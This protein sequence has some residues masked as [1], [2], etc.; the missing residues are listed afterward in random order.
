MN[1]RLPAWLR[2]R[3]L[4]AALLFLVTLLVYLPAIFWGTFHYDD[5]HSLVENPG[6]RSLANIPRFFVEPQLWSA[7]PG[8]LYCYRVQSV[9]RSCEG[10]EPALQGTCLVLAWDL[11]LWGEERRRFDLFFNTEKA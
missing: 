5:G 1:G 3:R 4:V 10:Y 2:D 8:T 9:V 7:E 11:H 6:I